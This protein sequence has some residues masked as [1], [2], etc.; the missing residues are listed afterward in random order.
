MERERISLINKIYIKKSKFLLFL[1]NDEEEEEMKKKLL[2]QKGWD[3]D[4]KKRGKA[5][6]YDI[7][8][9]VCCNARAP[10]TWF[11]PS[12]LLRPSQRFTC[13]R[14]VPRLSITR[15]PGNILQFGW[16]DGGRL[17]RLRA[18]GLLWIGC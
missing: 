3:R 10:I 7:Y 13:L 15:V 11:F 2:V 8:L 14:G 18:S 16:M 6:V 12:T 1:Q 5:R 4:L 17:Q 9:K